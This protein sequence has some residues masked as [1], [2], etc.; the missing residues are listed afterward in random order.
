[1]SLSS[2]DYRAVLD[3]MDIVYAVPDKGAMFAAV[4]RELAAKM[5]GLPAA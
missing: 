1:M 2:R 5:P 4:A 3:I